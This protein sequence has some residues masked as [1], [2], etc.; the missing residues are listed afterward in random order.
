MELKKKVAIVTGS[1]GGGSGRAEA[2]RF[3]REGCLVVVSDIDEPGGL[4]TLNL[5]HEIGGQAAFFRADVA[6][7]AEVRALIAFAE[8]TYGGVDIIVNN[9]SGP[10]YHPEAP[11][12]YWFETVQIDL[13]GAMYGT[14]HGIEA[15]RRREGGAIV[16]IGSTSALAHGNSKAPC[17]D[18][19]KMG[20]I[21][22]T[23]ALGWLGERERIRVNCLVPDWV[24]SPEV[25]SYFDSL[26]PEQRKRGGVPDVLTTLDEI[27]DAVVELVMDDSLSGRVM[28]WWSGKPRRLIP[29]GDP[30]YERLE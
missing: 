20:V 17:Y 2:C 6:V 28:V 12:E 26:T 15:M 24:A 14:R 16:N 19:A 25:K 8:D 18:V 22:L 27:S 13:L 23:T 29:V 11:L 30:G 9:A 7:E 21:R 5:I 3:A 1:G 10:G 4:Q